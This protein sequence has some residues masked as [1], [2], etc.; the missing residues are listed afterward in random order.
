MNL[1]FRQMKYAVTSMLLTFALVIVY[2][3]THAGL[4]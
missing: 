1:T 2:H 4:T 3:C